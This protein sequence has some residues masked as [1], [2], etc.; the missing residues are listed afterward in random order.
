M[1]KL[2][3]ER[4]NELFVQAGLRPAFAKRYVV[5]ARKLSSRYKIP[6]PARHKR[7]FCKNCSAFWV[8][9]RNCTFRTRLKRLIVRC[10]DCGAVR[11]FPLQ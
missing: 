8:P 4:I 1:K 3:L 10:L 11:R 5:L 2:A 9:G 6:I 7:S